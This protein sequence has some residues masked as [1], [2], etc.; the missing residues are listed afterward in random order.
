MI[1]ITG[2]TGQLGSAT[3]NFLLK[4]RPPTQIAALVR[5]EQKAAGLIEKG[6]I[7]RVGNYDDIPSLD[8]AMQGVD[9]VC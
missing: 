2:A 5:D 4:K 6:V 3:I 8:R 7:I 9:K 1:L